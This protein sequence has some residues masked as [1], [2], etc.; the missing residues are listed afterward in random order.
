MATRALIELLRPANVV[1]AAADVL[2]GAAAAGSHIQPWLLAST[3]CLYGGGIVLNDFFDRNLDAVERPERPIPSGRIGA[4]TAAAV[5][6]V[7]LAVG[8]GFASLATGAACVIAAAISGSVLLYDV[9]GKHRK[10]FGPVNMGICRA[11]NLMLGV[12]AVPAAVVGLLPL[13]LLPLIYIAA[14]TAISRGEVRGGKREV[15]LFS[16]SAICVVLAS[17]ISVGLHSPLALAIIAFL[18]WRVIPPFWH[19]YREPI[20]PTIRA[21]VRAGVLSLVLLDAAIAAGFSNPVYS[22]IILGISVLATLLARAF[23]VT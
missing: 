16:L 4:A 14:V 11:L 5:G 8:I 18:A 1:T 21:A 12:A 7:L 15:A 20:P 9:W 2:A 23:S 13:A 6:F 10:F 17:L 19:A 22:L 3:C